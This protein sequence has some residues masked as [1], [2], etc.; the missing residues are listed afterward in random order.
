MHTRLAVL[1]D[2]VEI[3]K[4]IETELL[5]FGYKGKYFSEVDDFEQ[6]LDELPQVII[7]DYY[8]GG[9]T[10]VDVMKK[11]KVKHPIS[12][13]IITSSKMNNAQLV[14][15]INVGWGCYYINREEH[16]FGGFIKELCNK[17]DLAISSMKLKIEG[18]ERAKKKD[19]EIKVNAL[20]ILEIIDTGK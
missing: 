11:V 20:S 14:D 13:F 15:I 4:E 19:E 8:L 10:G 16:D 18:V 17:I 7:T 5:K 1:D 3:L 6:H 9:R 12:T 2:D